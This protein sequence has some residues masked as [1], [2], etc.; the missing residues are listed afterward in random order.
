MTLL[1]NVYNLNFITS[2]FSHSTV[3]GRKKTHWQTCYILQYFVNRLTLRTLSKRIVNFSSQPKQQ[4]EWKFFSLAAFHHWVFLQSEWICRAWRELGK[5]K[6]I[7]AAVFSHW[8][9]LPAQWTWRAW[10]EERKLKPISSSSL[11]TSLGMSSLTTVEFSTLKWTGFSRNESKIQLLVV[12]GVGMSVGV[13]RKSS[14]GR[15]RTETLLRCP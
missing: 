8:V 2:S 10:R 1:I 7:S 5:S 15:S 6:L 3:T 4:W 13:F 14:V 9:C 11:F 12:V